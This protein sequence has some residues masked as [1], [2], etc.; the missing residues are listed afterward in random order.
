MY[1]TWKTH[2]DYHS[3]HRRLKHSPSL[4][5]DKNQIH[6]AFD[7]LF[8]RYQDSILIVSY[9]SDGIPS[10]EEILTLLK[11]YKRDVRVE[12]FG[13]Y[14]YVLS[15]NHRSEEILFIAQ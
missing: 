9:R 1:D 3:K 12:W 11:K 6:T 8:Q 4:W 14:K 15:T 5:T 13:Q 7:R 2:I 10:P